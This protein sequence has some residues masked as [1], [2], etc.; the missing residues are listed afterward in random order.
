MQFTEHQRHICP[1]RVPR[2]GKQW[3]CGDYSTIRSSGAEGGAMASRIA[4]VTTQLRELIL[5]G[6]LEPG[7]RLLEIP[8][9]KRLGVSR[10]PLR[11]ALG[12]LE[13]EGLLEQLPT[14]GFKV[15]EFPMEQVAN[16]IDVRG[17]LEGM[18]A[19]IVAERGVEAAT[20][21]ELECCLAEGRELTENPPDGVID[22]LRWAAMNA[23]FHWAIVRAARN[24]ALVSALEHNE[25]I[26]LAAAATITFNSAVQ[27]LAYPLL[28][29]AHDDHLSMLEAITWREGARAEALFREHAYR[30]RENK[31]ALLQGMKQQRGTPAPPGL[32][33]VVG[34]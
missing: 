9:A 28:R 31:Q 2:L 20:R 6:E 4:T 13:K 32:K 18:A 5:A 11:L 10:T 27:E 24:P 26:P 21:R 22:S 7:A 19:R 15:R 34:V 14:R 33:L 30:S 16:A 25:R 17:V 8:L 23:R 3:R 29:R 1:Q 12:E